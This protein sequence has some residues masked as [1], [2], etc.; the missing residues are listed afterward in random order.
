[1][2]PWHIDCFKLK[3]PGKL[4]VQEDL[5]DLSLRQVI[6]PSVRGALPMPEEEE[7]PY[8]QVTRTHGVSLL[9]PRLECNGAISA[10]HN[11]RLPGSSNSPASA[12]RGLT[13]LSG[14]EYRGS[15]SA[16]CI[17]NLPG[18]SNPLTS[19]SQVAGI[20][21]ANHHTWLI[22]VLFVKTAFHHVA[23]AGLLGSSHPL[24]SVSQSAGITGVSHT[25]W[26]GLCFL[27]WFFLLEYPMMN[28]TISI[29]QGLGC[30]LLFEGHTVQPINLG[31]NGE[32]LQF[33]LRKPR[34]RSSCDTRENGHSKGESKER[35]RWGLAMLPRL[36]SN[37]W[38]QAVFLP[39]PPNYGNKS[40]LPFQFIC[41]SFL[42]HK[43]SSLTLSLVQELG[44]NQEQ[45]R[46]ISCS[47]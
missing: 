19:T 41:I 12:S 47:W 46:I 14:L 40:S 22:F 11:L 34:P 25:A 26:P 36:V 45:L 23:Q 29:P 35:E 8:L 1:M 17:F 4:Q 44:K 9:L 42:G 2:I 3:E 43:N 18:L 27:K 39:Q 10:H 5:S 15:I 6:S 38:A 31:N 21:G 16:Q 13:L 24:A 33:A 32:K 37:F 28:L 7:H 20:T 30:G